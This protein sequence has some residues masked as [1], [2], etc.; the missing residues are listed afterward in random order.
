MQTVTRNYFQLVN[1]LPGEVY[2]RISKHLGCTVSDVIKRKFTPDIK[3]LIMRYT[4][5][6]QQEIKTQKE[7]DDKM[8]DMEN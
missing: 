2:F 6:I 5:E 4:L 8:K 3:F 7:L 1:S